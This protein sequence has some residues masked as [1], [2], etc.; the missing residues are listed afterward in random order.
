ME[1]KSAI[2]VNASPGR[3]YE[4]WRD[5]EHLPT[6]MEHLESVTVLTP[7]RSRWTAHAPAG[8][9]VSWDAEIHN[10]IPNQLIAW[11]SLPGADVPNA[12]SVHFTP[13]GGTAGTEVRVVLSYE[14]PA[15]RL[16]A[17]VAKLFGEEPG[18]QVRED[19]RRFKQLVETGEIAR[20]DGTPEGEALGRKLKQR[21]AQPLEAGGREKARV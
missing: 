7:L 19:L 3:V 12:G 8:T 13:L 5:F 14:P 18:I 20:S 21:P 15:G 2:T 9:R 1:A 17:A 10:E 16:G 11:R 6:F 4:A